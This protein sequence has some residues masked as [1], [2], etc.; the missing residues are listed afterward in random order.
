MK[1]AS[2]EQRCSFAYFATAGGRLA[3]PGI[4]E[5]DD[6]IVGVTRCC[7]IRIEEKAVADSFED[8]QLGRHTELDELG[9]GNDFRAHCLIPRGSH[10]QR[11]RKARHD[12][13]S[14]AWIE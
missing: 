1:H 5:P 6:D 12:L 11:R 14:L 2:P 9:V 7:H 3:Q 8:V 13:W 10:Q 4:E